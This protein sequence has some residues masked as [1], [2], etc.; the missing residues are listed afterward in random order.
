[1]QDQARD[2]TSWASIE[3]AP[4]DGTVFMALCCLG[5]P[6]FVW[7]D[8]R[9]FFDERDGEQHLELRWWMPIPPIPRASHSLVV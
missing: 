4:R 5:H 6:H 7:G 1:M 2:A 9:G 3:T 8:E